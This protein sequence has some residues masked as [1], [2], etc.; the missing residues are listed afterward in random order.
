M[1]LLLQCNQVQSKQKSSF[2]LLGTFDALG[3]GNSWLAVEED[4]FYSRTHNNFVSDAIP[5]DT[6]LT[7]ELTHYRSQRISRTWL[8][9][10]SVL[11]LIFPA[12]T[13]LEWLEC[14]KNDIVRSLI[15]NVPRPF[16]FFT[17]PLAPQVSFPPEILAESIFLR[18]FTLVHFS[19]G[20]NQI[21]NGWKSESFVLRDTK[22]KGRERKIFSAFNQRKNVPSGMQHQFL[23]TQC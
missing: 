23:R 11:S 7:Y 17:L 3:L 1:N 22:R 8:E 21:T 6:I 16:R 19:K 12:Q 10:Y 15:I 14:S 4:F 18:W 20:A 5:E 9:C 2:F 13:V